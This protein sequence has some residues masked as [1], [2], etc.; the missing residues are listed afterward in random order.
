VR[1]ARDPISSLSTAIA[2]LPARTRQAMLDGIRANPIVV[3]AYTDS[4]G[5]ICPMLAAHRH[6]G[7]TSFVSFARAWDAFARTDTVRRASDRELR[8][9][10]HLLEA[11]LAEEDATDLGTAIAEHRA[12][13]GRRVPEII[14]RRLK[15]RSAQAPIAS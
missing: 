7:R 4:R 12:A 15:P 5:G 3:G 1:K 8:T 14:A 9:L 6:G 2:C 11:S 13:V 10:A